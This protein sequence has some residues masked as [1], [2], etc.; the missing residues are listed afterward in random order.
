MKYISSAESTYW[1]SREHS[2][3]YND[4]GPNSAIN[5]LVEDEAPQ[6][7]TEWGKSANISDTS[8]GTPMWSNL[9]QPEEVEEGLFLDLLDNLIYLG[10]AKAG[11]D[12]R[13]ALDFQ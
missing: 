11:G 7:I 12:L 8:D 6:I 9:P 1:W 5:H 13:D 2:T 4:E 10:D 3:E